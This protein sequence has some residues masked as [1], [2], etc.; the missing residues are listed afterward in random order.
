MCQ[1][2]NLFDRKR[3]LPSGASRD[4][5]DVCD[6]IDASGSVDISKG[7]PGVDLVHEIAVVLRDTERIRSFLG[8]ATARD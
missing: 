3:G 7:L 6:G 5:G 4:G 8:E 1:Y 2:L